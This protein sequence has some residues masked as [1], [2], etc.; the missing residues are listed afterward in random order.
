MEDTATVATEGGVETTETEVQGTSTDDLEK[1]IAPQEPEAE[2]DSDLTAESSEE[3]EKDAEEQG[4]ELLQF[5]FGGNK[6]T[7]EKDQIPQELAEKVQSFGKDIWSDYTKKSSAIADQRKSL[8]TAQAAVDKISTLQGE[9]LD[10]YTEGIGIRLQG[11][12]VQA[13]LA[14]Y[15]KVDFNALYDENPDT[16][17]KHTDARA[18]LRAKLQTLSGEYDTVTRETAQ[19][20][21][22]FQKAQADETA[23]RSKEGEVQIEKQIKGFTAKADK[24]V[25]YVVKT[26]GTPKA[27]AETWRLNPA[28]AVMAY[29]A[30]MLDEMQANLKKKP[31]PRQV[32]PVKPMKGK[33]GT[34]TKDLAKVQDPEEYRRL[35]IKELRK[36]A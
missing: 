32:V 16:W 30:M 29:K 33:G 27:V 15:A 13:E 12:R 36:G 18:D 34:A 11:E 25:D 1:L 17:R 35:R 5:E 31:A 7:V 23:R 22:D 14:E 9:E 6:M 24:V 2:T 26:Y 20:N 21:Q 10:K 4:P 8:E 28:A 3:G 19:K